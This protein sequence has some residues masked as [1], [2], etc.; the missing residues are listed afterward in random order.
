MQDGSHNEAVCNI[1]SSFTLSE[2]FD[3]DEIDKFATSFEIFGEH[4]LG[5][6]NQ[7]SGAVKANCG[8]GCVGIAAGRVRK[9]QATLCQMFIAA[10]SR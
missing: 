9:M 1:V 2:E 7:S 10:R 4:G 6:S 8:I 5:T 3:E